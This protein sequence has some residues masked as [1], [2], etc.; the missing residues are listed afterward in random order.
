M[1]YA[2]D[3]EPRAIEAAR[4]ATDDIVQCRD[5]EVTVIWYGQAPA[6]RFAF[7]DLRLRG[8]P[9]CGVQ[10]VAQSR[11]NPLAPGRLLEDDE[12]RR[13]VRDTVEA[14]LKMNG[15]EIARKYMENAHV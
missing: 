9:T 11:K 7:G 2:V 8:R 6:V 5:A 15:I 14:Y 1:I 13:H 3:F 12:L 10:L 4:K